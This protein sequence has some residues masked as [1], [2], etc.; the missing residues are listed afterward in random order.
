M[1]LFTTPTANGL[2]SQVYQ[3]SNALASSADWVI[4]GG[5]VICELYSYTASLF[6]FFFAASL[7]DVKYLLLAIRGM[8][9]APGHF[10]R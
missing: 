9:E 6:F 3:S 2:F 4:N 1:R 5:V 8:F 10:Y 7:K